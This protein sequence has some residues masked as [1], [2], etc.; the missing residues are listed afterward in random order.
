M[1]QEVRNYLGKANPFFGKK[2][3]PES[4]LKMSKAHQRHKPSE[5][6]K[7]KTSETMKK[8]WQNPAHRLKAQF[9]HT[10]EAKEKIKITSIRM[11]KSRN[12]SN[13]QEISKKISLGLGGTGIPYEFS[14]YPKEF[15]QKLKLKIRQRDYFICQKCHITEDDHI[16]KLS[17]VLH[18]HHIDYNKWNCKENNL[19]A[20]CEDCNLE[21]N[22]KR[23]YWQKF[24]MEKMYAKI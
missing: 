24:Y 21:A 11:W 13:K 7:R 16:E 1:K 9:N 12:E 8:V 10:K 20:L 22:F 3:S 18:I 6:H 19:I 17:K 4:L 15:N 23:K 5:E 2:H 14:E